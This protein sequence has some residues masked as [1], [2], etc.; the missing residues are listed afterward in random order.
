MLPSGVVGRRL[1][2]YI[3]VLFSPLALPT[4]LMLVFESDCAIAPDPRPPRRGFAVRRK[5]A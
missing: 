1:S 2:E 3:E 4:V 5:Y